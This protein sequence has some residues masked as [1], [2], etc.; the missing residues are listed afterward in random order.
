MANYAEKHTLVDLQGMD[1]EKIARKAEE[2]RN[3]IEKWNPKQF[4]YLVNKA[5][6]KQLKSKEDE[7]RFWAAENLRV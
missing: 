4:S 5:S 3:T 6:R 2:N 7:D 1:P